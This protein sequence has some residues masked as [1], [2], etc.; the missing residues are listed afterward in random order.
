LKE[1]MANMRESGGITIPR[2]LRAIYNI[3]ARTRV[4]IIPK[5]EGILIKPL[6]ADPVAELRGVAEGLWSDEI[7]SV[8]LIREL[9]RRAGPVSGERL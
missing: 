5:P 3:K 2:E 9:R 8:E 1:Y 7:S 6:A 4:K